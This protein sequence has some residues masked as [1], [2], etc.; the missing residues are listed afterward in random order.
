VPIFHILIINKGAHLYF[1]LGAILHRYATVVNIV[2]GIS[3][4]F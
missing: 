4:Y 2:V 3:K 1:A